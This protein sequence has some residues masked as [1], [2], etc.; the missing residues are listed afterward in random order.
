MPL[1]IGAWSILA[2]LLHD[3]NRFTRGVAAVWLLL[4]QGVLRFAHL[5]RSQILS[6]TNRGIYGLALLGKSPRAGLRR[7]F[8]WCAASP[9]PFDTIL[10]T[11]ILELFPG[12]SE[13][14]FLLPALHP[15]GAT[16]RTA[17]DWAP[18]PMSIYAFTKLGRQLLQLPPLS[19]S[20]A[21]AKIYTTYSARRVCPTIS[22]LAGWALE[23][24]A[25]VGAW[26]GHEATCFWK[27]AAM[28]SRYA[29]H[30]LESSLRAKLDVVT[31]VRRAGIHSVVKP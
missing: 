5:Q 31:R 21:E 11:A 12:G 22:E 24:R 19:L 13:R 3:G 14:N 2:S 8:Y 25:A 9:T 10:G 18:K 27:A 4:L 29:R 20:V 17:T 23:K 16:L 15:R 26:G 7:P 1:T 30:K 28:P 6:V